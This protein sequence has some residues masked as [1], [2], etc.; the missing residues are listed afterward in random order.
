M[1]DAESL[2]PIA[3][4]SPPFSAWLGV[5]LLFALFGVIVLALVGPAPRGDNYEQ[6]RVK[7][8]MDL[9]KTLRDE[10]AKA[11]TSYAWIDKNKGTARIPIERAMEL[12][13]VDLKQKKPASAGPIA[14]P[15]PVAAPQPSVSS[16]PAPGAAASPTGTP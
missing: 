7:K 13:L 12:T 4:E 14:T 9:L 15:V 8:R 11:L 10:D 6:S 1:A 3:E 5:V 16:S 2:R